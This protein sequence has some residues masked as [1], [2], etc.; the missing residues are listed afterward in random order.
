MFSRKDIDFLRNFRSPDHPVVSLYLNTD[1]KQAS[2][3][4]VETRLKEMGRITRLRLNGGTEKDYRKRAMDE[5]QRVEEHIFRKYKDFSVRG[6]AVF[7]CSPLDFWHEVDLPRPPRN[8]FLIGS[9]P[10][11]RPLQFQQ[12]EYHRFCTVL[13]D[14]QRAKIFLIY[15]GTILEFKLVDDDVPSRVRWG[16]WAGYDEKRSSR[17]VDNKMMEHFHHVADTLFELFKRDQYEWLI[18]GC[19]NEYQ[20]DFEATLHNYLRERVVEYL[21]L[22]VD[23]P[24]HEILQRS[25]KVEQSLVFKEHCSLV[26]RLDHTVRSG[27]M[28][29]V[30]LEDTLRHLNASAVNTLVVSRDFSLQGVR[31][32]KCNYLGILDKSCSVCDGRLV[33]VADIVTEAIDRAMDLNCEVNQVYEGVGMDRLGNIGAFTRFRQ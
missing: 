30:G 5:L 25:L 17:K 3:K 14:R 33:E 21:D 29:V 1:G 18:I 12:V 24:E 7:S 26:D 15:Q 28:A 10:Y 16:G 22:E 11:I 32:A 4:E 23:A 8:R 31:C 19:R 20:K 6:L 13:V 27:G 9:S 2:P